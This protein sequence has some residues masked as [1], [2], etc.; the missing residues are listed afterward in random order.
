MRL[1]L[2][3]GMHVLRPGLDAV[4]AMAER[5]PVAPV[6]EERL[7]SPVRND[8]VNVCGFHKFPILQALHTQRMRTQILFSRLLPLAAV[9]A[10]CR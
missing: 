6:P 10:L 2:V 4:M 3:H 1:I 9:P 8:M 5:L 7:V